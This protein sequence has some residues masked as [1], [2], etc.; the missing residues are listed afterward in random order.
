MKCEGHRQIHNHRLSCEA[1]FKSSRAGFLS[2]QFAVEIMIL[3]ARAAFAADVTIAL[4][5]KSFQMIIFPLALERGYMKEEGVDLKITFMEPTPSIQALVADS[6]QLTGSGGSAMVAIARGGIPAKVVLAVNDRVHQW[7]LSRPEITSI[8]DLKGRKIATTG[9]A[10]VA[11]YMFKNLLPKYG[12]DGNKDVLFTD[13]GVGNQAAALLS[14]AVDAAIVSVE[15]RYAGIDNGM[16]E[17]MYLGN[18]VK[19]SWGTTAASDKFMKEQPKLMA[20]FMRAT[21][22]ALRWIRRDRQGTIAA[23]TRFSG[24]PAASATRMYDDLIATF[25]ANGAVDLDTQKNDVEV[26]RQVLDAKE[27]LAPARA[28]DF[29]FALEADAQINKIGWK[30]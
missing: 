7:I 28:F 29:S 11:T 18:E 9:I 3:F 21:L 6:I 2:V 19:N 30:P 13:P 22:K 10:S 17:L 24:L 12:I 8:K 16:K 20:G 14:G 15:Q 25:T 26:I 4:P 27:A 5:T 1:M 23:F